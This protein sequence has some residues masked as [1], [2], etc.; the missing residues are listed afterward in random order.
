[1]L[2]RC[3]TSFALKCATKNK[4][5]LTIENVL[6]NSNFE[7]HFSVAKIRGRGVII[8]PHFFEFLI[9][10]QHHSKSS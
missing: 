7:Y 10:Y 2:A 4:N 3:S 5:R 8:S 6:P 1:M 9:Y